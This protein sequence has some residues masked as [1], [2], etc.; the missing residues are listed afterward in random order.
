MKRIFLQLLF[1]SL[2]FFS[3]S[4][5]R[6]FQSNQVGMRL[7]PITAAERNE[8]SYHLEVSRA[9]GTEIRI[10]MEGDEEIKRWEVTFFENG[11]PKSEK[12]WNEGKLTTAATYDAKNRITDESFYTDGV[13]SRTTT[14]AYGS[15]KNGY[16]SETTGENG[17]ILYTEEYSLSDSGE[18]REIRKTWPDGSS[19]VT[20]YVYSRMK[21]F[22]MLQSGDGSMT[23]SRYDANSRLVSVE[24]WK[25]DT[26]TRTNTNSYGSEAGGISTSEIDNRETNTLT[27]QVYDE[28]G[29][30]AS[31]VTTRSK[32]VLE[33]RTYA[34]DE[35][36]NR[37]RMTRVS[38][39]G[40]EEWH[41][42]Y[43][44]NGELSQED[45]L[46]KG[47]LE[48]RTIYKDANTFAEQIYD[49]GNLIVIAYFEKQ[50]KV[51]EQFF[52]NGKMT[53]EREIK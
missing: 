43:G 36:G 22:G 44:D 35:N 27:R 11:N 30:L 14:Y 49:R 3:Y 18:L 20:S 12:E 26:L 38:D 10:L 1:V 41:Y 47:S 32:E 19:Q 46:R 21:M 50:K 13:L 9:N 23:I 34:Y 45:Y 15:R 8:F 52:E 40:L 53:R 28:N 25:D 24:V 4:D 17:E 31:E 6:F 48:K 5:V 33:E 39:L 2:G 37:T 51:K 16:T 7:K 29:R 42:T